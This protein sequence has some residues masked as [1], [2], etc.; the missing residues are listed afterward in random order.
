[1]RIPVPSGWTTSARLAVGDE[2][3]DETG[4]ICHVEGVFAVSESERRFR[5]TFDDG[6]QVEADED[7]EWYTWSY[8]E[9]IRRSA[10]TEEFRSRRRAGRASR[11]V[12]KS[13]KPWA[14]L[15]IT[16]ENRTRL[17]TYIEAEGGVRTTA[18]LAVS[19]GH[20]VEI[21]GA[22]QLN[23]V[24]LPL[25]PYVFGVW[26]GDGTRGNGQFTGIDSE[27]WEKVE[28]AGF[29]VSH[30]ANGR[31]HC[32]KG[33]LTVLRAMDCEQKKHVPEC[34][35]RGSIE[36]RLELL[37]GLMDT[38]GYCAKDGQAEFSNTRKLLADTVYE[39]A[40]SLGIKATRREKRARLEGRDCGPVYLV[41][42]IH[43]LTGVLFGAEAGKTP[44]DHSRNPEVSIY[45][46]RRALCFGAD[47]VRPSELK[48]SPIP[49]FG[50]D[51]S[52]SLWTAALAV[53]NE[54]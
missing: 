24:T 38:D 43:M 5:V 17:H 1:M 21:A 16:K 10:L 51:D 11:A 52:D 35:L 44:E 27:I 37:R 15:S 46:P 50:V 40:V 54:Y 22:L 25:D 31:T 12:T 26:L 13:Q 32:I 42:W 19:E 20:A 18:Q 39:L 36:Q 4:N 2:L 47:E 3:F 7:H 28:H 14:S 45:H 29:S 53:H 34:Y 9:R 23:A 30:Y 41:Y 8:R 49:L 48:I 6:A 33:L